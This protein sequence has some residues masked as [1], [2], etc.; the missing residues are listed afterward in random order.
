MHTGKK[1]K[2][3]AT[4]GPASDSPEMIRDLVNAGVNVFRFNMKHNTTEWHMERIN[5]VQEVI[6]NLGISVGILIDLQGPEIRIET[7]DQTPI[8]VKKGEEVIFS[9]TFDIGQ[10][11]TDKVVRIPHKAVIDDLVAGDKFSIDDG[12]LQFDVTK[13]INNYII[14]TAEDDYTIKHRKGLNLVG[15]DLDLPSLIEEDLD[16][17]GM[18]A[19]VKVDYFALSFVRT[20]EDIEVLR[21]ELDERDI[22]AKIVAKIES[23][24]GVDNIDS[25]I[26]ISDGIMIARGDLGIE[27]P[28]E[29][30]AYLQ[31][32]IIEKCRRRNTPVIVATQ[33]L[34]SMIDNPLPT[35]AEAADVANAVYDK[36]DA[37]MLSGESATGKYPLKTVETMSRI[38]RFNEYHTK[39]DVVNFD[40]IDQTK[41][42]V[43]SAVNIINQKEYRVDKVLVVSQTGYTARVLSSHRP[44]VPIITLSFDPK[45]AETLTMNYGVIPITVKETEEEFSYPNSITDELI[46]KGHLVKDDV[47]LAIHGK[48]WDDAGKTN[49]VV[50]FTV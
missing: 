30:I 9:D 32:M 5:R 10:I 42:I 8:E 3:I 36:T 20:K 16:K 11:Y 45:T 41:T 25:I 29:Q 46:E 31:K 15:K 14:A 7:K 34:Q 28:I 17:L 48:K 1:T 13:K 18:A 26:D 33:M 50:I 40:D 22:K 37:V 27:V 24:K 44:D 2:I 47:V 35:R 39:M 19:K 23:Q 38:I 49:A 12:F 43:Q 4:I 21:R 6:D